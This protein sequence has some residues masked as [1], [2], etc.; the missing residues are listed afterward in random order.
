MFKHNLKPV[1]NMQRISKDGT[2]A[3]RVRST[4]NRKVMY[5]NTGIM[6]LPGEW[7]AETKKIIIHQQ[8]NILNAELSRIMAGL[9]KD[10][11]AQNLSGENMPVI[12][13]K[14][15]KDFYKYIEDKIATNK[16]KRSTSTTLHHTSY[17]KKLKEFKTTLLFSEINEKLLN[18]FEDFCKAKGNNNN[19]IWSAGKFLKTYIHA[20]MRE[21][22]L[23]ENP[24]KNFEGTPYIDPGRGW[25]TAEE[26]ERIEKVAVDIE[27]YGLYRNAANWFLFSCYSGLRYSDAFLFKKESIV[28]N[29]INIRTEKTGAPVTILVHPKLAAVLE[30][31][32][33]K[34]TSNQDYNRNLK[35][36]A[37]AAKITKPLTS[38][39]ARHTFAVQFLDRG[40]S[41]EVLSK[42]LGHSSMK[43]TQI[44]G[45]ITN[46]RIDAEMLKVWG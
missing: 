5:Y 9:E 13:S 14:K 12:L 35:G 33:G 26:I 2:H 40:G 22:Y 38:H 44:Y 7:D 24:I 29:K 15:S 36:V 25:L 21:G 18:K 3:L 11:V 37:Q 34:L 6:L 43:T 27:I 20:A 30:R 23:K 19:T 1:L 28:N 46:L 17:L 8:R 31:I 45:K 42:L 10:F 39:I 16:S 41:M 32:T 4:I